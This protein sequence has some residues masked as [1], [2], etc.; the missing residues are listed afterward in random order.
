MISISTASDSPVFHHGDDFLDTTVEQQRIKKRQKYQQERLEYI[1]KLVNLSKDE[2]AWLDK[3]LKIYDN[4]RAEIWRDMR[5]IRMEGEENS[6]RLSDK[7]Y[8]ELF[9]SLISLYEK[10]DKI[11][12]NFIHKLRDKFTAKRAFLIYNGIKGHNSRTAREVRG[13]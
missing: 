6:D 4:A 3:E 9:D 10:N 5:K 2:K 1:T 7:Q 11:Q 13:R 12:Q 8:S